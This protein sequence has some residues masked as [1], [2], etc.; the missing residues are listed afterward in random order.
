MV[1]T[2][3]YAPWDFKLTSEAESNLRTIIDNLPAMEKTKV[4]D[5]ER[6]AEV[7]KYTETP[8][9][10]AFAGFLQHIVGLTY[11]KPNQKL[12]FAAR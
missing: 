6:R 9:S 4:T 10:H 2:T 5:P 11:P 7:E 1:S 8:A 3:M 12:T